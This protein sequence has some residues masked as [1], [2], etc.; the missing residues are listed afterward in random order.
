MGNKGCYV[1]NICNW[2]RIVGM[3]VMSPAFKRNFVMAVL[4]GKQGL[5]CDKY[6]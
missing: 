3:A 2:Y 6:L 1:I 4:H 5:L